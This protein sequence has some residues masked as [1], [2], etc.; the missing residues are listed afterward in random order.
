MFKIGKWTQ[1]N[2]SFFMTNNVRDSNIGKK[3]SLNN[4]PIFEVNVDQVTLRKCKKLFNLWHIAKLSMQTWN[5]E[6]A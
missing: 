5:T 2:F 1:A 3:M 6:R 4:I